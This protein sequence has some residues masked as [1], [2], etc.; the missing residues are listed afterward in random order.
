MAKY[1]TESLE[2]GITQCRASIAALELAADKERETIKEYRKMIDELDR[3]R[4]IE[5]E[6]SSRIETVRDD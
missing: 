5:S 3:Q 2:A 4:A 6:M 1:S